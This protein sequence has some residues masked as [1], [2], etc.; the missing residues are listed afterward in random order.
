M[1]I[2]SEKIRINYDKYNP[3]RGGSFIELPKWIQ[4][5]KASINIQNEDNHVSSIVSN[6]E[7]LKFMRR[8]TPVG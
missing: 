2:E 7:F 6:A 1:L 5:K 3:T 4:D 8:D